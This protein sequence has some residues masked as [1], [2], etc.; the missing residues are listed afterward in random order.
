VINADLAI[1]FRTFTLK[2]Y[3]AMPDWHTCTQTATSTNL[4]NGTNHKMLLNNE[5]K[6]AVDKNQNNQCTTTTDVS[7]VKVCTPINE[8]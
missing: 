3:Q 4:A 7:L 5:N 1:I 8:K 2:C 6:S